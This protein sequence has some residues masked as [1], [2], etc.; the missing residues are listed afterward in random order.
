MKENTYNLHE[1]SAEKEATPGNNL[2]DIMPPT[3]EPA[4]IMDAALD[5]FIAD[6]NTLN[7]NSTIKTKIYKMSK[8]LVN[9]VY[10]FNL[11][12]LEDRDESPSHT[13]EMTSSFIINKLSELD[14]DSKRDQLYKSCSLYV[15]PRQYSLGV[16]YANNKSDSMPEF[17]PCKYQ[18]VPIIETLK[19]LFTRN[20]FFDAYTKYNDSKNANKAGTYKSYRDGSLAASKEFYRQNPLAMDLEISADELEICNPIGSK[21]TLHKVAAYYISVKNMPEEYMSR[22]DN[23]YL[24]CICNSDDLKTKYTDFNDIW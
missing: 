24:V 13:L 7:V 12:L 15:P 2:F 3:Q 18:Y 5:K 16:R 1:L 20:D 23:I 11:K 8:D 9:A 6:V 17:V 10:D 4:D 22:L 14:S 21:A 19:S